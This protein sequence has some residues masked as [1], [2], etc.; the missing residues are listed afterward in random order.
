[1]AEIPRFGSFR[2]AKPAPSPEPPSSEPSTKHRTD[3]GRNHR[4][5]DKHEGSRKRHRHRSRSREKVE[6]Q[7]IQV[8]PPVKSV[9]VRG[10]DDHELVDI[11]VVDRRG[12]EKNL[13]YGSIHRYSVPPFHRYG[14][15]YVLGLSSHF[16]IDRYLGDDKS[17]SITKW[18][19]GRIKTREKYVFSRMAKE[20][21]RLLRIRPA[22]SVADEA[23][24]E[25]NFVP[26]TKSRKRK[27]NDGSEMVDGNSSESEKDERD[28]RSIYGK[29]KP[30]DTP[31]D[32]ELQYATE[33]DFSGSDAG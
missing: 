1:M 31:S 15:G 12:D 10:P 33:S 30:K 9:P 23:A 27:R 3:K 20:K 26:L 32:D 29:Q 6:V 24:E 5:S 28:Y 4:S 18:R 19:D 14:A 21:P 13:T 11:F 7:P 2:P 25:K 8:Q 16:R 17:L 22:I